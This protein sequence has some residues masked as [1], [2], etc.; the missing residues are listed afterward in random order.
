MTTGEPL[1]VGNTPATAGRSTPDTTPYTI[2]AVAITAPV[3]PAETN[4]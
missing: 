1:K 2:L 4:P 3:L